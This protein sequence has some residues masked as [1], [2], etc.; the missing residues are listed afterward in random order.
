[1]KFK[2]KPLDQDIGWVG[3]LNVLY[4]EDPL[5]KEILSENTQL[6]SQTIKSMNSAALITTCAIGNMMK[7][8]HGEMPGEEIGRFHRIETEKN[9]EKYFTIKYLI[10]ERSQKMMDK[11]KNYKI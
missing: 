6:P 10:V 3:N 8:E 4:H 7:D 5:I 11:Q 2:S 9:V 1:M